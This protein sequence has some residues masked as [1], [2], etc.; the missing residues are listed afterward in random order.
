MAG[1]R[2]TAGERLR[3]DDG[4][5]IQVRVR[6]RPERPTVEAREDSVGTQNLVYAGP[7]GHIH[8]LYWSFGAVGHDDL[9]RLAGAPNAAGS[10]F[11]YMFN[12]NVQNALYRAT[13]GH[14]HG[15]WWS[16]GPVRNDD[17]TA[18]SGASGSAANARAYISTNDGLQHAI[19]ASNDGHVHELRW[20]FGAV[21]HDDLTNDTYAPS[22]AS[23]AAPGAFFVA[24]DG[25][26]HVV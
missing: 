3:D 5:G 24:S 6:D 23:G 12:G 2:R 22:P 15:L 26:Q 25:T 20:S 11:A 10:P 16:Q 8:G 13:D 4:R 18:L 1:H 19:Y 17:L 7:D 9:S 21:G 14:L